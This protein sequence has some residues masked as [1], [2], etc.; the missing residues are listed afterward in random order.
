MSK[1]DVYFAMPANEYKSERVQRV[2]DA[3][4]G[5]EA[6][7]LYF[8]KTEEHMGAVDVMRAHF[9]AKSN[10]EQGSAAAMYY[11]LGLC[12]S[13]KGAVFLA[14]E[15]GNIGAGVGREIKSFFDRGYPVYEAVVNTDK[16]VTV[17]PVPTYPAARVL[18]VKSTRQR[19]YR[20][21]KLNV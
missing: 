13:F 7:N 16:S 3:F 14:L 15:D 5:H 4:E 9:N 12:E 2:R 18:D 11:W 1:L 17:S 10:P 19:T 20:E 21:G 6:L 8:P